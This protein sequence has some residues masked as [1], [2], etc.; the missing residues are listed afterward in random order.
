MNENKELT[1]IVDRLKIHAIKRHIFLC[2]DPIKMNCCNQ[3]QGLISWNFLKSRL[4]EL[5]L[6]ESG[7]IYRSKVGCLRICKQGPIAVVY[8]EGVWYHSCTPDV[9]ELIIQNHVINGL[10]VQEY[11][12]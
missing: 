1:E 7:G 12:L 9:L 2:Y 10:P 4:K 5:E 11:L 6:S 8:P 3:K